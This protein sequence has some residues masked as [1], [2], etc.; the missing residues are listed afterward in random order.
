[1]AS[2][3]A[4]AQTRTLKETLIPVGFLSLLVAGSG[5]FLGTTLVEIPGS[6]TVAEAGAGAKAAVEPT[7]PDHGKLDHEN[8]SKATAASQKVVPSL[9]LKALAPIV[10]N[11]ASPEKTWIR[12]QGSIVYDAAALP[13]PD[14]MASQIMAD[15]I[16]F[17]R[18][19]TVASIEGAAGLRR[20]QED[21]NERVLIRSNGNVHEI[22]IET[23]VV[24]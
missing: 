17:L 11:L 2:S 16:A 18:T 6:N 10:T 4:T 24:Q 1:M 8:A 7:T 3:S 23:L 12:M 5:G 15:V 14:I 22:I 9:Q 13:H 19:Q 20:L 21:L